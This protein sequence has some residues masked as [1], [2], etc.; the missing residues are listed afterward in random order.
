MLTKNKSLHNQTL[1][2]NYREKVLNIIENPE[3]PVWRFSREHKII[4]CVEELAIARRSEPEFMLMA[5]ETAVAALCQSQFVIIDENTSIDKRKDFLQLFFIGHAPSG[6]GKSAPIKFTKKI[7]KDANK[8]VE[9][10]LKPIREAATDDSEWEGPTPHLIRHDYLVSDFTHQALTAELAN[11]LYPSLCVLSAEFSS[12]TDGYSSQESERVLHSKVCAWWDGVSEGVMRKTEKERTP[13]RDIRLSMLGMIQTDDVRKFLSPNAFTSGFA[14]RLLFSGGSSIPGITPERTADDTLCREAG[15][16]IVR[17]FPNINIHETQMDSHDDNYAKQIKF[18]PE[19]QA[20][21]THFSKS[22]QHLK[23]GYYLDEEVEEWKNFE[24]TVK[25][26]GKFV[27]FSI[28]RIAQNAKRLAAIIALFESN[29]PM[30]VVT[31]TN[32][33]LAIEQAIFHFEHLMWTLSIRDNEEKE[34]VYRLLKTAIEKMFK[35]KKQKDVLQDGEGKYYIQ[36]SRLTDRT[37]K[38]KKHR[39]LIGDQLLKLEN[40]G[41][42]KIKKSRIYEKASI[43]T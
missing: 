23:P 17:Y 11:I 37:P 20:I 32:M 13:D 34:N 33:E 12:F 19:A 22:F 30:P 8:I 27:L 28:L 4:A 36:K 26:K 1:P 3:S 31:Q 35:E 10:H 43:V 18:S 42:I 5:V 40:E 16:R 38:L 25:E 41:L 29:D 9:K 2:H 14:A 24:E 21:F 6:S 7:L 39:D 15:Q